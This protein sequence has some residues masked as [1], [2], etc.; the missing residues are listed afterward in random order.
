[1]IIVFVFIPSRELIMSLT[2]SEPVQF[3]VVGTRKLKLVTTSS[4]LFSLNMWIGGQ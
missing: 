1:M 3:G 4:S 2:D